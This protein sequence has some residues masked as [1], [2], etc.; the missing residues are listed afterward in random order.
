MPHAMSDT[1]GEPMVNGEKVHSHFLD[2]RPSIP[3]TKNT[4]PN[5]THST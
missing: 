4:Q 1:M 3:T 2:V 5:H